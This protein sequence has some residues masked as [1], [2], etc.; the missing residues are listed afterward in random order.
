MRDFPLSALPTLPGSFGT[1]SLGETFAAA[2]CLSNDSTTDVSHVRL[3]VEM[4]T[5]SAKV[6]LSEVRGPDETGGGVDRGQALPLTVKWEIKELGLHILACE[7]S[8]FDDDAQS[9][10]SFRK[11]YKSVCTIKAVW[12]QADRSH[13]VRL[14]NRRFQVINPLSVKTKIHIPHAASAALS[15]VAR[16]QLFLELHVQNTSP[17]PMTFSQMSFQPAEGLTFRSMNGLFVDGAAEAERE[18]WEDEAGQGPVLLPGDVRQVCWIVDETNR[19]GAFG[20]G[21]MKT[22]WAPGT[23]LPLG[24]LDIYWT[25]PYGETGHL[26]TSTLNRRVP[27]ASGPPLDPHD[28]LSA[29]ALHRNPSSA[30]GPVPTHSLPS[31]PAG[32]AAPLS[33]LPKILALDRSGS[34]TNLHDPRPRRVQDLDGPTVRRSGV[35]SLPPTPPPKDPSAGLPELAVEGVE[36]PAGWDAEGWDIDLTVVERPTFDAGNTA[37]RIEQVFQ[38]KIRAVL[39]LREGN[40]TAPD[41]LIER[42]FELHHAIPV[43]GAL[44]P[45]GS[46]I[47]AF[48]VPLVAVGVTVKEWTL[49]FF[50]LRPGLVTLTGIRIIAVDGTVDQDGQ[51]RELEIGAWTSLGEILVRK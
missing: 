48:G 13:V 3:R 7:I 38:V 50:P 30:S 36:R 8:W 18:I 27:L 25:S 14:P 11:V 42:A 22:A 29:P 9:E 15:P 43:A 41:G 26:Q 16:N 6:L 21:G 39:K 40:R 35:M 28:R 23:V 10:R 51:R 37:A 49:D 2:L 17:L 12:F 44:Q 20:E 46:S 33:P 5:A 1:I 45:M 32:P 24:K 31:S 4:Q 34:Q 19:P 47:V